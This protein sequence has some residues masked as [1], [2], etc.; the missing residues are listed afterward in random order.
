MTKSIETFETAALSLLNDGFT[1]KAGA[2]RANDELAR[3]FDIVGRSIRDA[4]L[5]DRSIG[6]SEQAWKDLYYDLPHNLHAFSD[7]VAARYVDRF[8]AEVETALRL[9]SIREAVKVAPIV[10]PAKDE[11]KV[12]AARVVE[13]I[14]ER[15]ERLGVRFLEA[16][17][18]CEV[19]PEFVAIKGLSA[20]SHYVTNEHGTTFLRTFYYLYGK[21]TPLNLILAAA[22]EAGRRA[23][24]V[25]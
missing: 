2:K 19:F 17:D 18:L 3:A 24:E 10:P 16:I 14:A 22:E 9:R 7:K 1:S 5:A 13:A 8:P 20:N 4:L 6:G 11:T 23:E 21:L 15:M 12:L 25:A